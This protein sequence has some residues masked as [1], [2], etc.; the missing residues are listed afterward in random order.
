MSGLRAV[1][2]LGRIVEA[3][4]ASTAELS[5]GAP[6]CH[7]YRPLE[8]AAEACAC[9]LE[10]YAGLGAEVLLLGMNPGPFGMCQTGIPFGDVDMARDW[11]G[12]GAGVEKPAVQHPARPILGFASTRRE[13]SGRRIW[14]WARGT[15]DEADEFFKQFFVWNY[16]PLA[17]LEESGRN[18]TPDK[19]PKHE[20]DTL[21]AACDKALCE[22]VSELEIAHVIGVG[23]FAAERARRAL[24]ALEVKVGRAPHPSPA[25]P[26]ANRNWVEIFES[27]LRDNGVAPVR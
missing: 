12:I 20:R 15:Y 8:Y 19:L 2:K 27:A 26:A 25:S 14:G 24:A 1:P 11:L 6:V 4:A 16:C 10:R 7:V 9:Y 18:R 13:V 5:F 22:L 23:R 3:L 21:F 17:F